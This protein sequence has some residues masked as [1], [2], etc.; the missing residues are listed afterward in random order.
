MEQDP[1]PI[2]ELLQKSAAELSLSLPDFAIPHFS[3]YLSEL[4]KWN[5]AI[6]LTA[7]HDDREIVVKHFIDSLAGMKVIEINEE[8]DLLDVGAGAG[9][10]GIPMK[11]VQPNLSIELLEP[12]E[13]KSSFLRYVIGSLGLQRAT[14][15]TVKLEDYVNRRSNRRLFDYIVVRAFKVDN[16]GLALGSLLR[17][18]GKVV[19][20]RASKVDRDF[21]LDSLALIRE[22]EYELPSG[23]GH[24]TLSVFSKRIA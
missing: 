20:Y 21:K 7:I 1:I 8:V 9:F 16:L 24:R 17:D 3:N 18:G 2:A 12:S 6:N 13:K 5:R 14:V 19:L 11:F 23:C 4:K 22:V 15:A 10:P